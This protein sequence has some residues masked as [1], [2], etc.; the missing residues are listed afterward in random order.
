MGRRS[1]SFAA[2]LIW[3]TLPS[4]HSFLRFLVCF[5]Q[6]LFI[7]QASS[8]IVIN[9]L[10]KVS[11]DFNL[12]KMDSP[13]F[14]AYPISHYFCRISGLHGKDA[15]MFSSVKMSVKPHGVLLKSP[16]GWVPHQGHATRNPVHFP[17]F[18]KHKTFQSMLAMLQRSAAKIC[19]RFAGL[20]KRLS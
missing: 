19:A 18:S 9:S 11:S 20:V 4:T 15:P 7:S 12:R 10:Y 17:Q 8:A 1:F 5:T 16:K 13:L 14:H 3:N 2:P 6:D